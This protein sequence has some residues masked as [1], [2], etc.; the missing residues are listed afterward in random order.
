MIGSVLKTAVFP[1]AKVTETTE[2]FD[3]NGNVVQTGGSSVWNTLAWIVHIAL[4]VFAFYLSWQCTAG[5]PST[6][7]RVLWALLASLFSYIYLIY[8]LIYHILMGNPCGGKTLF[9]DFGKFGVS[10]PAPVPLA[11]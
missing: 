4:W 7:V 1:L 2:T 5:N 10:A 9:K 8:Y 6:V 11:K 3:E